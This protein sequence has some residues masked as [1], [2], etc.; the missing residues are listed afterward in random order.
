MRYE[1]VCISRN[2][3]AVER[4]LVKFNHNLIV[5]I[6]IV[7]TNQDS[8][9]TNLLN[10][11]SAPSTDPESQKQLSDGLDR[12]IWTRGEFTHQNSGIGVS[13]DN[14]ECSKYKN[15]RFD[16][17]FFKNSISLILSKS[18]P[19]RPYS[20]FNF[21]IFIL[22]SLIFRAR[23]RET[24]RSRSKVNAAFF[25]DDV[26]AFTYP[27]FE[28]MQMNRKPE[29]FSNNQINSNGNQVSFQFQAQI[30]TPSGFVHSII[31]G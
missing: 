1:I 3:C 10:V 13:D 29:K 21:I 12:K 16:E 20:V 5:V 31:S 19:Q 17:K 15:S 14:E 26:E 4:V 8:R 2:Y 23:E 28:R 22:F 6:F 27:V 18:K 9:D 7:R 11:P 24:R 30:S 25:T